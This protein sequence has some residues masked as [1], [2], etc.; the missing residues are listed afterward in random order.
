MFK[1]S[2]LVLLVGPV[3]LFC[4]SA[5][6]D[7]DGEVPAPK[8]P[9]VEVL[10]V[11]E[12]PVIPRFEY[13]GR[14]EAIDDLNVRP[15]VDGYIQSRHFTEG[16]MVEK[17]ELLYK[18][19][20][21]PYIASLDN[22]RG[23]E[24]RAQAALQVA[25]RN[26]HRGRELIVTGAISKSTMDELQGNFEEAEASLKE[27]QANVETARLNLSY[28]DVTSP[29]TGR[30][31]RTEYTE[32]AL[33]GPQVEPPLTTIVSV[34]PTYVQFEVP[35]D[36]LFAVQVEQERRREEGLSPERRDIRIKQ[37]DG[38]YYPHPGEI[39]FVDNQVNLNTGSVLVRARFPNPEGLLVQGQFARVSILVF[40]GRDAIKPLVPQAAV[41][42]DMQGRF[43]YVVEPDAQQQSIAKQRYL[44]LG[45]REGELWAV[46][47]GINAGEVII[48]NGLQR[49]AANKPV[50]PQNTPRNPYTQDRA[51][52]MPAAPSS[53][54]P[55][56]EVPAAGDRSGGE[57][58]R[59]DSG[60]EVYDGK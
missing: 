13:V 8:P 6:S 44:E 10:T 41:M 56:T 20:P 5:C 37:P 22:A 30:A 59:D 60:N 48:V 32:G 11:R 53:A 47:K 16:D 34:N 18:I 29:L 33:V 38:N 7:R 51:A 45:Q 31:G 40:S 2:C 4:A 21:R 49:V 39:V 27:A 36:R 50:T 35:E 9:P 46:E 1:P 15:R 55:S 54:R 26:Y 23:A 19:D 52:P 43:V 42:E 17:G 24:S 25:E 28:T 3:V 14:V 58:L 12:Q 57:P